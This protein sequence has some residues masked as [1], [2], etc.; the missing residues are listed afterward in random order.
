MRDMTT[1]LFFQLL[2]LLGAGGLLRWACVWIVERRRFGKFQQE[3]DEDIRAEIVWVVKHHPSPENMP[4]M[5][6]DLVAVALLR[7]G[8]N[9]EEA[10]KR[11]SSAAQDSRVRYT[12]FVL[13]IVKEITWDDE[14]ERD[15]M[16]TL[17]H[18]LRN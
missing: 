2:G 13:S 5:M 1:N 9:L 10:Q 16:T 11:L 8:W 14:G 4:I 12:P 3:L 15:A 7:A 18:F 17:S 6:S